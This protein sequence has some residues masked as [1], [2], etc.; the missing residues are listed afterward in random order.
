MWFPISFEKIRG[1]PINNHPGAFGNP[2]KYNFHEGI[3]LYG[4]PGDWVNAIRPGKVIRNFPFTGPK[5][6]FDW[7]LDTDALLVEDELG[8]YVY[9]EI[10]SSLKEGDVVSSGDKIG[11]MVP[12]LPESKFRSD[13]P[14]HSV[15]M[16]HLERY[17]KQYNPATDGWAS[18]ENRYCR[19]S[20]LE[21]PTQE[22][23]QILLN[24]KRY[25]KFL[26]L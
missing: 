13:I 26:T 4:K 19:P 25:P 10:K 6:G 8:Y 20:Y 2:R 11:E 15:C 18:W 24:K 5:T 21:D 22:L 9:G 14:E 12:V 23:I 3:D 16:L 1:L 7:W 17:S